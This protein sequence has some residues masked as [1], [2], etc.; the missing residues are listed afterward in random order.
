VPD[1][2]ATI[3]AQYQAQIDALMQQN[4]AL[5]QQV[6]QMIQGG[7]QLGAQRAQPQQVQQAQPAPQVAQMLQ[8]GA[9]PDP[10]GTFNPPSLANGQNMSLEALASEI[11]K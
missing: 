10:L 3:A 11:G 1:V 8:M 9:Q 4:A 7:A 2:S 5:N 6:V